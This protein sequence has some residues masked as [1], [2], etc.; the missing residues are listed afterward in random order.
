M[1]R[2]A[3]SDKGPIN[4]QVIFPIKLLRKGN[5]LSLYEGDTISDLQIT[6]DKGGVAATFYSD[7]SYS[8]PLVITLLV[9]AD[10]KSA[11]YILASTENSAFP[12]GG[13]STSFNCRR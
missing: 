12:L 10:A 4:Q 3:P 7:K 13:L 11:L 5:Q 9:S 2:L 8:F 6:S 1:E